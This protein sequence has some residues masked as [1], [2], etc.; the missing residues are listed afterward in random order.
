MDDAFRGLHRAIVLDNVDPRQSRRLRI[1]VPALDDV[2]AA[3]A[4]ACVP[5]GQ[6]GVPAPLPVDL[7]AIGDIVWVMVEAADPQRP[8]WLGVLPGSRA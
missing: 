4:C 2:P 7:P 5:A 1:S 6:A 3:W 8:V